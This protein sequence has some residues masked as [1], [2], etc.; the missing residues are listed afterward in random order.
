[1]A[2]NEKFNVFLALGFVAVIALLGGASRADAL[3][4]IPLRLLAIAFI[5]AAL[6]KPNRVRLRK[7]GPL[8][9][10]L[11]LITLLPAMQLVPLPYDLW[12]SVPANE[13]YASVVDATGIE[14]SP[15][16]LTL[17][18]G[19]TRNAL[20]SL[21]VPLAMLT[22]AA[23]VPVDKLASLGLMILAVSV[24]SLVLGYAQAA[25][26]PSSGLRYYA[27]TNA[28][29]MVGVFANRNHHAVLLALA[30]PI[31]GALPVGLSAN[32]TW[33]R[34][35][36]AICALLIA[37]VVLTILLTGSRAGLLTGAVGLLGGAL[38]YGSM[39]R[40]QMNNGVRAT[41]DGTRLARFAKSPLRAVAGAL[42]VIAALVIGL[43][44]TPAMQR[45]IKTN[46][47]EEDRAR[48]LEPILEM[49][50]LLLPFGGG[51]GSFSTLFMRF[52]TVDMLR[53]A[54]LNHAHMDVLQVIVEGGIPAAL[55]LAA[56]LLWWA[57]R[58][59]V[60][61]RAPGSASLAGNLGRVGAITTGIVMIASLVDY[62]L[63]TPIH[64]I[65]FVIGCVFL[66]RAELKNSKRGAP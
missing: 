26:G 1:M 6:W 16:P 15:R 63:R 31:V 23:Q 61:W 48:L 2:I 9:V 29:S 44:S 14:H 41:T 35:G 56:F 45:L 10:F 42:A 19:A 33:R 38:I 11:G 59:L 21:L 3:T 32:A 24:S 55:L 54:Y 12:A 36:H 39:A 65:I 25:G 64:M 52:E 28:D 13:F 57:R 60:A 62:P 8:F 17:V 34:V 7:C 30:L 40:A 5:L 37:L 27:V 66:Q 58:S 46:A 4:Q 53:T 20:L 51:F 50:Q 47:A 43:A 22:L 18:P 49:A